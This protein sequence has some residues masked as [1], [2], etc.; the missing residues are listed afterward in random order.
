MLTVVYDAFLADDDGLTGVF[1][2]SFAHLPRELLDL[3]PVDPPVAAIHREEGLSRRCVEGDDLETVEVR[4]SFRY[5]LGY[6]PFGM[7]VRHFLCQVFASGVQRLLS[8]RLNAR[9]IEAKASTACPRNRS[10]KRVVGPDATR[11]P[12]AT[13]LSLPRTSRRRRS[14]LERRRAERGGTHG[15]IRDRRHLRR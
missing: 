9:L 15:A 8:M 7:H 10:S 6:E 13:C 5:F 3:P 1:V 4:C 11:R 14:G 12:V 2:L